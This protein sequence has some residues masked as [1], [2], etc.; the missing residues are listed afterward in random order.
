LQGSVLSPVLFAIYLN[1]IDSKLPLDKRHFI[2][3]YAEN[4]LLVHQS[5]CEWPI[6]SLLKTYEKELE[7]LDVSINV[8]KSCCVRIRPSYNNAWANIE[9]LAGLKFP[10]VNEIR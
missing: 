9:T 10:W 6:R 3:L 2:V 7:W 1:D 5:I 4:I 8:K